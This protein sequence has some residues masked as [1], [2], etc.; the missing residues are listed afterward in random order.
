M[1]TR[2]LDDKTLGAMK[3]SAPVLHNGTYTVEHPKHG[4]FTVK[5]HTAAGGDLAG[6]RIIS[7]LTGPD[8]AQD[9]SGVA[10]WNEDGQDADGKPW[11][12]AKIWSKRR[13]P[14]S[15]LPLD[16]Y[17]YQYKGGWSVFEQKV[18]I[19]LDLALR[20]LAQE[21]KG[22]RAHSHFAG[23]GY[24]ILRESRCCRCNRKLTHPESIRLG[25]GPECASR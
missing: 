15:R 24:T 23:N 13:G 16:G 25:I 1:E 6:R 12:H 4:H 5:V 2:E 20:K 7:L 10:F 3:S 21:D 22:E 8:N 17:H 19:F 14:D 9:Y 11:P 18:A